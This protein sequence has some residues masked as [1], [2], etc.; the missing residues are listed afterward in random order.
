MQKCMT[1]SAHDVQHVLRVVCMCEKIA[2]QYPEADMEI[3]RTAAY[4]HDI[5]REAQMQD[6]SVDHAS[7]GAQM[8]YDFLLQ[9]GWED[10]RAAHVRDCIRTHRFRGSDQPAT[11]EA[12]ILFD[13]DK[14]DVTGAIGVARTLLYQ[15]ALAAPLYESEELFDET[16]RCEESFLSE[17]RR[18]LCHCS[19]RL[20]TDT[21]RKIAA[22]R[23]KT[24]HAFVDA[25]LCE[26]RAD[27][28]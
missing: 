27:D 17:Y 15:G 16:Y 10:D 25:L 7:F 2:A 19:E 8:A 4:L 3:L 26:A 14:L 24:M 13:S 18:K 22:Q 20:F 6:P 11:I 28:V 12:K 1:D 21:A 9:S 23:D 5:G